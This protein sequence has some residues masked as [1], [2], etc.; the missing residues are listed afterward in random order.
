MQVGPWQPPLES[1]SQNAVI[2]SW[3]WPL[4]C[5]L[6]I[7]AYI[8]HGCEWR[9]HSKTSNGGLMRVEIRTHVVTL[10]YIND[11]IL[12]LSLSPSLSLQRLWFHSGTIE[13]S[14]FLTCSLACPRLELWLWPL[15]GYPGL[16]DTKR[17][18]SIQF[19]QT[20]WFRPPPP[21]PPPS[22]SSSSSFNDEDHHQR[23]SS[24]NIRRKW[25]SVSSGALSW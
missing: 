15:S 13:Q 14:S 5:S 19:T 18:A 21:P 10:E 9:V 25:T 8:L 1:W 6:I 7:I 16:K 3:R 17:I 23:S 12:S 24:A 11:S 20:T 22:S 2:A 4:Q